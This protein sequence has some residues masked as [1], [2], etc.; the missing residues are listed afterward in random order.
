MKRNIDL[1]LLILRVG[2]AAM[3]LTH[4]IPKFLEFIGGNMSVVGDPIGI[5]GLVTTL[6]VIL[7]EFI[8]PVLILIGLKTRMAA[9]LVMILMSVAALVVH[10]G[11]PFGVKEKALLYL[12]GFTAIALMGAGKISMDKK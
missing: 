1:G 11:D 10:A 2:L 7:A 12:V 4:G 3:L 8:A 6:L 9:I 5:G